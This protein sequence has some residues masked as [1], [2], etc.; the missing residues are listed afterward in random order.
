MPKL[1]YSQQAKQYLET[2]GGQVN[3]EEFEK[4]YLNNVVVG[5][6]DIMRFAHIKKQQ[7]KSIKSNT[8]T[9]IKDGN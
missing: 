6:G 1:I 3:L 7:E 9:K 8:L 4:W 5:G 2:L